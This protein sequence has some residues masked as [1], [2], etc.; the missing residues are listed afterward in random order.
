MEVPLEIIRTNAAQI[1]ETARTRNIS[2]GGVLFTSK[3]KIDIGGAIEYLIQLNTS[4]A[5]PVKL[6]CIGKVLRLEQESESAYSIA[7]TLERYQFLRPKSDASLRNG[8]V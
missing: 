6:H 8:G 2:S 4:A 3:T 5:T 7:A 1:P